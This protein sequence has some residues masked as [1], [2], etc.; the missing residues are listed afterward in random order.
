MEIKNGRRYR[1]FQLLS[2]TPPFLLEPVEAVGLVEVAR[3][4]AAEEVLTLLELT[5][6][7]KQTPMPMP[8]PMPLKFPIASLCQA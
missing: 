8:L 5:H 2:S 3:V 1:T 6:H 4:K 7:P